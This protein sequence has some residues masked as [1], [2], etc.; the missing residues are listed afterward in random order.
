AWIR[1]GRFMNLPDS[2]LPGGQ[3]PSL[4]EMASLIDAIVIDAG[5]PVAQKRAPTEE[6]WFCRVYGKELGPV[7]VPLLRQMAE[8]SQLS[9]TDRIRREGEAKWLL[10]D[11]IP[12]LFEGI[13]PPSPASPATNP[14]MSVAPQRLA[15]PA[16]KRVTT[17]PPARPPER[18]HVAAKPVTA[19]A[20]ADASHVAAAK[21]AM[22]ASPSPAASSAA[23]ANLSGSSANS[24]RA[25]ASPP[26]WT[27]PAAP[28]PTFTPPPR[29]VKRNWSFSL[30]TLPDFGSINLGAVGIG[31]VV[32]LAVSLVCYQL[33]LFSAGYKAASGVIKGN[34]GKGHTDWHDPKWLDQR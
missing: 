8:Q 13:T 19:S 16:R 1:L 23:P 6:R 18:K 27:P 29:R 14:P 33:G 17:K 9:P 26:A 34:S 3:E 30:P 25:A 32:V 28:R 22:S 20:A 2:K 15:I 5:G 21:P 31:F 12:G 24:A 10:A 11:V 4:H 7:E